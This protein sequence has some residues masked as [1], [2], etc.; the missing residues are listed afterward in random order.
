MT[1]HIQ[2]V[3]PTCCSCDGDRCGEKS[4]MEWKRFIPPGV[5][6]VL[7]AAGIILKMPLLWYIVAYL[8]VGLPVIREAWGVIRKKDVFNE[9]TL[10]LTAT[11]GA[12]F[13]G[14]YPEGVAVMLFYSVGE[15]FQESAVNK[16]KN[17][18][19]ALLDI[20][21]DTATALRDG[22]YLEVRPEEVSPGEM[23]L[24]KAGE[25]VP[26]DGTLMSGSGSF[27]TSALT[28]ESRPRTI[29]AGE[30]VLAGM[31][32]IDRA[33]E[34]RAEKAY[35]DSSLARILEMVQEAS[36]RKAR[37]E[38]LIR[39]FAKVYTPVVFLLAVL[40]A[41]A[42]YL[43]VTDYVFN[44]WL[45][46]ALI[47]LVI[48][49]PC[50]L[51]ISV[52]LGYFGGIGAA[53]RNG[54]LFKGANFLDLMTSVNTVVMDKTG[55]L[56]KGVF[57]VQNIV[58]PL[59]DS[60]DFLSMAA[61]IEKHSA[62][63]VAKAIV[64]A[65]SATEA[66]TVTV[67]QVEE[68][69]GMGVRGYMGETEIMAGNR[70]LMH[71]YSIPYDDSIDALAETVVIVAVDR[72]YAGYISV[73]DE[74]KDDAKAAVQD[75][76]ALGIGQ[77]IMLSGDRSAITGQVA[78]AIG[79]DTAYGDLLPEGKMEHMERLKSDRSKVIAFVGDG[80]NDAPALALSDVGIAMGGMG[81]DAAIEI[82]DVVIQTDQP[83]RIAA[84]IRI[85]KITKRIVM[86]NIVLAISVKFIVMVMGAFGV[87]TMWEAVF[88][89]VGVA[90][91]AILNSVRILNRKL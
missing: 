51:V 20:R 85:A 17:S 1:D 16:A 80:I 24:V 27:N 71:Q 2:P 29:R 54:I 35:A 88:A 31:I 79:I 65:S 13:I 53:S 38:L 74:V 57:R 89:D 86:Q 50:A 91:L 32:S 25:K 77:I 58:S 3:T 43:F 18:I 52:P 62:H 39:K 23:L 76:Y 46:R 8:P 33:V 87:A 61:A 55:T 66:G 41:F 15:L 70:R 48:S 5:S 26:L 83:S 67:G 60:L 75:M 56:T 12:F 78:A 30:A 44:D 45:Y 90:L 19:K 6:L 49:C 68:L 11:L 7:L 84:A 59:Y 21:P 82:A 37:T 72:R 40:I 73:A 47:F 14:E 10:M 69:A 34:I 22:T 64:A 42:P 36:S 28:G 9:Y 63:P 4:G 81:S